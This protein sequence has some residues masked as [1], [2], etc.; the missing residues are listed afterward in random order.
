VISIVGVF[1][2]NKLVNKHYK[3]HTLRSKYRFK[4]VVSL[5][6]ITMKVLNWLNAEELPRDAYTLL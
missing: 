1:T 5:V 3:L 6:I 4:F 2:N